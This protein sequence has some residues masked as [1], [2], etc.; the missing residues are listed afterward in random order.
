MRDRVRD[1]GLAWVASRPTLFPLFRYWKE[2]S[3]KQPLEQMLTRL[4]VSVAQMRR[5]GY[6]VKLYS[7]C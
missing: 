1:W 7:F 6:M 4:T 2:D 5:I 3:D